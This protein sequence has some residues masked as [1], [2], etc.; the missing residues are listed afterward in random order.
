MTGFGAAEGPV[1]GGRLRIE[2]RTVN[3]RFFNFAPR[4][5][6]ELAALEGEVRERLRGI[7]DRGHVALAA[8]WLDAPA[9]EPEVTLDLARAQAAAARLRELKSALGLAG[10]VT[11]DLVARQPEV[12][13]VRA[14]DGP[15]VTFAE[16]EP[17]VVRAAEEC[18]QMRVREGAALAHELVSRLDRLESLAA[19]VAQAAPDRLVRER[20]RLQESVTQLM[21]GAP[22]DPQRLAQ[23]IALLA[24]RLD[25]TEELVRFRTHVEACRAT[26]Q[27]EGS[28]G[29]QLGFLAQELGREANTMGSKA[30]DARI[31]QHVIAM[32]GELEK[33]REQLEN[34]A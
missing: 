34:L 17:V 29:K 8:R 32:K 1:A 31:Q 27:G 12:F 10:E 3:H 15:E 19:A 16:V 6:G 14:T 18:R 7:L 23:E 11:L 30:S 24:D 25:I 22:P 5:P 13:A 33:F 20:N 4:L 26:L 9:Q 2:V 28:A 21:A